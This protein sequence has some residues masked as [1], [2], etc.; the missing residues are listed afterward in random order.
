MCNASGIVF[1]ATA[2]TPADVEGKRVI[3]V[4]AYDVNGSLRPVLTGWK[5]AEYMGVDI[6]E[7]PGVDVICPV[8]A[9][10]IRHDGIVD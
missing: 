9:L 3:E 1:G 5:P 4:G 7:G 6:A 10:H 2:L 8:E